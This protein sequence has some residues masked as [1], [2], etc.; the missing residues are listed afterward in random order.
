MLG[1]LKEIEMPNWCSNSLRI[2]HKDPAKVQLVIDALANESFFS[3]LLPCPQELKD[4]VSGSVAENEKEAH[5]AQQA[6]NREKFG[7]TDWYE[8][9][10]AVWGTKWDIS[11]VEIA[12]HEDNEL[13][14]S[15]ASAWS[16]PLRG[17][18]N[19]RKLGY[20]IHAMYYESGMGFCGIWD[21]GDD[22]Y[23]T[24]DEPD[25]QEW[26]DDNLPENLVEEMG[27]EAWMED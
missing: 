19:L 12:E 17:Y 15:F 14:I 7:Y 27:I 3:T 20:E 24:I 5:E 8:H 18:K 9:N 4:T 6:L 21:E 2:G 25:N 26:I 16:P 10:L 11:E 22:E 23:Y 13:Y 1:K